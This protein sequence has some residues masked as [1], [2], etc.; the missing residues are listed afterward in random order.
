MREKIIWAATPTA[1]AKLAAGLTE[2][3]PKY[4]D[5]PKMQRA[6][7]MAEQVTAELQQEKENNGLTV[8]MTGE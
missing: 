5:C 3:K 7:K 6:K 2:Q 8:G 1:Q 4:N